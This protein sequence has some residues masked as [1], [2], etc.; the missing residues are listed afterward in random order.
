MLIRIPA[1]KRTEY[2]RR[3]EALT[4]GG[5]CFQKG[6]DITNLSGLEAAMYLRKSRADGDADTETTLQR[7]RETLTAYA[8]AHGIHVIE[9]YAEVASG[10]SLRE[11]P[12]MLRLLDDVDAG[13]YQAVLCMDMD[14][15]S[16]GSMREQGFVLDAFKF[17]GTLIVTPDRV[18]DLSTEADEQ[19]AEVKTFISRQEYRAIRGRMQK[20]RIQSVKSGRYQS[21]A[22]YGYRNIYVGKTPTLEICEPEAAFVRMIFEMFI[23]GTGATTIARTI[24][25]MGART[26]TGH[27]FDKSAIGKILSNPTYIGK[28]PWNRQA[29]VKALD[30]THIYRQP[31]EKWIVADG[32]HPAIID[33]ETF[34]RAQEIK[35]RKGRKAYYDS[36]TIKSP[37]AGIVYCRNC[38]GHMQRQAKLSGSVYLLCPKPGCCASTPFE[39]VENAL[40]AHLEDILAGIEIAP[41]QAEIASQAQEAALEAIRAE[42]A[43]AEKAKARLYELVEVGAYSVA[44]FRERMDAAKEK[45]SRL[46][47]KESET[48]KALES[49]RNADPAKQAERIR[50]ALEL[51]QSKDG[52]GR[53]ALLKSI[54]D[55]VWYT[56]KKGSA[57]A[58]FILEVVLKGLNF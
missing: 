17:S 50:N 31:R 8:A 55:T 1:H 5:V 36:V 6:G 11:R 37:L 58:D 4:P 2:I 33:K 26:R 23:S 30:G 15:L 45:I 41:E 7:H 43:A 9:T 22:P 52:A 39:F 35:D 51:Y 40:L 34:D 47:R 10:D 21:Q 25:G 32:I 53:N 54:I 49:A 13:R 27:T 18:Y 28:V 24:N 57:T 20:G 14:R 56:K 46:Q 12:Q 16:R 48:V 44:E 38:G 42:L 19:F 29:Q 3:S